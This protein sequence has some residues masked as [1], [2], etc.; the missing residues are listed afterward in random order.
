MSDWYSE[1]LTKSELIEYYDVRQA[2]RS[3]LA[4]LFPF[5]LS[6][7][8]PSLSPILFSFI[9][10]TSFCACLPF[11]LSFRFRSGFCR[12]MH[13]PQVSGCYVLR[14]WAYS[15]WERIRDYFDPRIKAMGVKNAYFPLF[16]SKA[17]LERE[18]DHIA[19]FSP[20]VAWV[21]RSGD[22]ELAEPI[23]VRPTSETV[24]YPAY[25]K[26]IQSHR[27]LPLKVS[28]CRAY[29]LA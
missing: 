24:M 6:F 1:V 7:L 20:E 26:W 12:V 14:P 5:Y 29:L 28:L 10:S 13:G 2:T 15:M 4:I 22:S 3:F 17:A 8:N 25:A 19:D 11:F 27:D 21:T 18:K 9:F 16:V 23:A